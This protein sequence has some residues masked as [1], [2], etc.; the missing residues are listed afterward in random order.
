[1]VLFAGTVTITVTVT[2]WGPGLLVIP[3]SQGKVQLPG[4]SGTAGSKGV[5][6]RLHLP[7]VKM[8]HFNNVRIF[9]DNILIFG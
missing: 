1:M 5:F 7:Q 9:F 6:G 3:F 4:M 8:S 2:G